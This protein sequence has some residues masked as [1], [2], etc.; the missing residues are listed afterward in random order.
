MGVQT[1]SALIAALVLLGLSVNV[2]FERRRV[3][4]RIAFGTLVAVFA[5]YNLSWFS[6]SFSDSGFWLRVLL[7]SGIAIAQTC[8]SFFERF[9]AMSMGKERT[10]ISAASVILIVTLPTDLVHEPLVP[11]LVAMMS[12]GTY[13]WCIWQL[14]G[15]YRE[16]KNDVER[17]RLS[18]LVIG[19]VVSVV[20]STTDLMPAFGVPSPAVGHIWL[21]VYMYFWM[22]VVL[23]SRLLDLQEILTRGIALVILS[24]LI[25]LVYV[26]LLIW[27]DDSTQLGLFFFNTVAASI[28]L[29]FIFEPLKRAV[30]RWSGRLF[31][32]ARHDLEI[33]LKSL[34]R[35]LATAISLDDVINL[36]ID[37]LRASRHVTH[38]SVFILESGGQVYTLAIK[39][40]HLGELERDVVDVV[41]DRA[42]LDA[43]RE[44]QVLVYE[45]VDTELLDLGPESDDTP[46]QK[47]LRDIQAN[48]NEL[49]AQLT[50]AFRAGNRLLGFLN[51]KD[52]RNAE[53]FSTYEIALF[54]GLSTQ[55]T[56]A[57]ENSE[58]VRQLK[59]RDRLSALGE[60]A[61]GMAHEIRNPLGAI[62]SAAQLFSPSETDSDQESLRKVIVDEAN[63]LDS[64]LSQFLN[65]ARPFRGDL[66][67]LYPN[68]LLQR[69]ATLIRAEERQ[70]TIE[71]VVEAPDDLPMVVGD[72]DQLHQVCLNLAKNACQAMSETGGCLTLAA[73][74]VTENMLG[75]PGQ[76][77]KKIEISVK[78]TG[79]GMPS[80]VIDS[81]FIPF[82][83]TKTKG[84]GL[85]LPICQRLLE[86]HGTEVSVSSLVGIGTTMSFRLTLEANADALTGEHRRVQSSERARW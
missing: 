13:A 33:S 79:P 18:Y 61:T 56:T 39:N 34:T 21:T 31:F 32:R 86:H 74:A 28:L 23:R 5:V 29:F 84:T 82:F 4:H 73:Q 72:A 80:T 53:A 48:M 35:R 12:L 7:L 11:S 15:R 16:S 71:V 45:Q 46:T 69:V 60:M 17:T 78:D 3:E 64:V 38:A 58:L 8:L 24:T 63:R 81:L 42:F 57:I 25:S 62:K 59:E 26:G 68:E 55:I 19:G 27:V 41:R 9:L 77:Q 85:G 43:L 67:P 30:D 6:Y 49:S 50:F 70:P 83:T 66:M 20:L 51:L 36:V 10:L 54:A 76:A 40:A 1:Q 44:E 37:S 65:F 75:R 47:R 52:D 14:Y 2:L 22:Q